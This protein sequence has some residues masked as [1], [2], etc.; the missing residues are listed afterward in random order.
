VRVGGSRQTKTNTMENVVRAPYYSGVSDGGGVQVYSTVPN[1]LVTQIEQV[2]LSYYLDIPLKDLKGW[3][4]SVVENRE[5]LLNLAAGLDSRM[6]TDFMQVGVSRI[7]ELMASNVPDSMS[8]R[9]RIKKL[10]EVMANIWSVLRFPVTERIISNNVRQQLN[11]FI[12]HMEECEVIATGDLKE[13]ADNN[14]HD[15]LEGV[16]EDHIVQNN[17]LQSDNGMVADTF[18]VITAA[19]ANLQDMIGP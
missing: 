2:I 18:K 1:K 14:M 16:G 13:E 19:S 10:S 11:G 3:T 7:S 12:G 6:V 5:Y 17:L 4:M 15:T 8:Q 9:I